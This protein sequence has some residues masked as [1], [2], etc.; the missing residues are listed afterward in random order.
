[1]KELR[2]KL[3]DAFGIDA[4][5]SVNLAMQQLYGDVSSVE[6]KAPTQS[7]N[8]SLE[9]GREI[10]AWTNVHRGEQDE[11]ETEAFSRMERSFYVEDVYMTTPRSS[12]PTRRKNLPMRRKYWRGPCDDAADEDDWTR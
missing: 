4:I 9:K 3:R 1:M 10:Q 8:E 6:E 2:A 5:T 7:T 12:P 11:T